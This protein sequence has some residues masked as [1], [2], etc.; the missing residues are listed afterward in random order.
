M[1]R[2]GNE[3]WIDSILLS[4]YWV[5]NHKLNGLTTVWS[6]LEPMHFLDSKDVYE[7]PYEEDWIV[8]L[9]QCHHG[10]CRIYWSKALLNLVR[11]PRN[12]LKI[13]KV[14]KS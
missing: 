10:G 5:R 6:H 1:N 14:E 11:I 3:S 8:A 7:K 2:E 13:L 12:D 9:L 4:F